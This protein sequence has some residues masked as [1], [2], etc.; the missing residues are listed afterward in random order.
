[1]S[2]FWDQN[3]GSI[4]SGLATAG[5]YGYQ[6]TKFVAKTGYKAGK[7]QY[8]NS[9]GI[10]TD[11][12]SESST[13]LPKTATP[14]SA[15][16]DVSGLPPP[17]LKPGQ[18]SYHGKT[19]TRGPTTT[20]T[21]RPP[22]I[23]PPR[24]VV[25]QSQS[26]YPEPI[27]MRDNSN[28]PVDPVQPVQTP[29]ALQSPITVSSNAAIPPT[30]Q[31]GQ[32]L[33]TNHNVAT[34]ATANSR[35]GL[36]T[37]ASTATSSAKALHLDTASVTNN[38]PNASSTGIPMASVPAQVSIPPP[39]FTRSTPPIT[40]PAPNVE[41]SV[42]SAI[43]QPQPVEAPVIP[44]R[45]YFRAPAALPVASPQPPVAL[46]VGSPQPPAA[47]PVGLHPG[48][49]SATSDRGPEANATSVEVHPYE[50]KDPEKK[51]EE[52]LKKKIPQ[53]DIST[54]T[55]P[56]THQDRSPDT[57][58]SSS[59][60]EKLASPVVTKARNSGLT[61]Q[62]SG[63][64]AK[65]ATQNK[66]SE[67]KPLERGIAGTYTNTGV[68]NFPPPP[69]AS[70]LGNQPRPSASSKPVTPQTSGAQQQPRKAVGLPPRSNASSSVTL[71]NLAP[72]PTKLEPQEA[73][74]AFQPPPKPFRK[75]QRTTPQ[76]P[77]AP[78]RRSTSSI[79]SNSDD[80][81]SIPPP[82]SEVALPP[83]NAPDTIA[84]ASPKPKKA[85]PPKKSL[86]QHL[87]SL[88]NETI[89]PAATGDNE[90]RLAKVPPP[91]PARK[92]IAAMPPPKPTR[93]PHLPSTNNHEEPS[94]GPK[95]LNAELMAKFNSR[96]SIERPELTQDSTSSF[97][98]SSNI[99]PAAPPLRMEAAVKPAPNLDDGNENPF[100]R[101]LKNAVP[102]DDDRLHKT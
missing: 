31:L 28:V 80:T 55:P 10:T 101:Y 96:Q 60:R 6:G 17:P 98:A 33:S 64:S 37:R 69:K 12:R 29:I 35:P 87:Q 95:G 74:A 42:H 76:P 40:T 49:Y 2:D 85:P 21:V 52:A 56:P 51:R 66:K 57:T 79:N 89:S 24:A 5:K 32:S 102:M 77:P 62:N 14:V 44:E 73:Q 8:N 18:V 72:M 61:T 68:V 3:K 86:P 71:E 27:Q 43:D 67:E 97:I 59:P 63:T 53:K 7:Q 11:E 94:S 90:Q 19:D 58:G 22:P 26:I 70:R 75:D 39:V 4:K 99:Q 83:R 36:P 93:K 25:P 78:P 30:S 13:S 84:R 1:M 91:K 47:E 38:V 50:W 23:M 81:K 45:T 41:Q 92:N 88:N 54:F 82:Y 20:T 65:S 16:P 48:S 100:Q 9:R 34:P 46:S 15:L